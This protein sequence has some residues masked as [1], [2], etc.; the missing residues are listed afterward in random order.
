MAEAL[1]ELLNN[2]LLDEDTKA[3]I[4]EAWETNLVEA[5]DAVAIELREEFATRYENDKNTLVK[6]WTTC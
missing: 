1:K 4:Q 5:R 3:S 6:P 2:D